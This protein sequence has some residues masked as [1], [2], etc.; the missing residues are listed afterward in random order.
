M[1][2]KFF[3][4]ATICSLVQH[5]LGIFLELAAPIHVARL[6]GCRS[7]CSVSSSLFGRT[8]L[9]RRLLINHEPL[10]ASR[11]LVRRCADTL[12]SGSCDLLLNITGKLVNNRV[13][14]LSS[15]LLHLRLLAD[16]SKHTVFQGLFIFRKPILLP[17][18]VHYASVKLVSHHT[19]LEEVY[20]CFVVWLL[21]ELK[22]SAVLHKLLETGRMSAAEL[23]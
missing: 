13:T 9:R 8:L 12:V 4:I 21:L 18:I 22:R 14:Y 5:L 10:C 23:F 16:H 6:F 7:R 11:I 19:G 17:G 2:F 15:I 20:A 3:L 1:E